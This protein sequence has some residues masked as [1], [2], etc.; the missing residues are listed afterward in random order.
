[1]RELLDTASNIFPIHIFKKY[2]MRE[3]YGVIANNQN[4]MDCSHQTNFKTLLLF[5][6]VLIQIVTEERFHQK[7]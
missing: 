1:M 4:T 5:R 2:W 3:K 7:V 6:K